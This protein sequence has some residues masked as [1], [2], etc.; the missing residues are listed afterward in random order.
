MSVHVDDCL[1]SCKS[2]TVMAEFKAH[3]LERF[4]GEYEVT[5]YPGCELVRDRK[6]RTGQLIQARY[7]GRVL[8]VFNL[9]ECIPVAMPMNPNVRPSKLDCPE[10][11]D[12]LLHRNYRSCGMSVVFGQHDTVRSRF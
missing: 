12:P 3:M 4:I 2:L 7:V 11:V 9:W 6:S 10:V 1:L 5:E 8:C